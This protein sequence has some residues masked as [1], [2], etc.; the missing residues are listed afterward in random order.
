MLKQQ[1]QQTFHETVRKSL[2]RLEKES[3]LHSKSYGLGKDKL[4]NLAKHPVISKLGYSPPK[5]EIHTLF[6][7]HEII[8]GDIFVSL[9]KTGYLL[10]WESETQTGK[11]RPDAMAKIS[12]STIYFEVERGN[13]NRAKLIK[14]IQNYLTL[15]RETKELF[16]LLFV[17]PADLQSLLLSV[18]EEL[19]T[20]QM[21][22][23]TVIEPFITDILDAQLLS[24]TE[25]CT[26][27]DLLPTEE[28]ESES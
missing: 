5:G 28:T 16:H 8:T 23:V 19:N 25:S 24:R 11:F 26:L 14:K 1:N 6:Y 4:W 13:Q 2:Q 22:L 10:E 21:Y 17:V 3:L 27:S 12:D 9:A 15:H 18:F 20:P 7:D